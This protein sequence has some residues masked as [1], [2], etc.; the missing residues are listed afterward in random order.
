MPDDTAPEHPGILR[1]DPA[2]AVMQPLELDPAD[3]QSP[4]PVQHYVPFFEDE[5][6]G[7][8]VGI[9]DTTTMQEAFGPYPGDEFITV[10]DGSFA[11]VDAAGDRL[12]EGRAGDSV[13]FRNA[14]P[15]SWK[16][17]GYLRKIYLTLVPPGAETPVL[18]SAQGGVTVLSGKGLAGD[19]SEVTLFS[20][21][22][23]TMTVT[24]RR[25]AEAVQPAMRTVAHELCRILTGGMVL[26]DAAGQAHVLGPGDHVFLPAGLTIGRATRAGTTA[27]HV[28]VTA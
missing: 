23:G 9:W 4:L 1:I 7:L 2:H 20:N 19:G 28:H 21:D 18:A 14:I 22:A 16:Q 10:L 8:A 17:E 27:Y 12:A 11:M 13:T 3:F 25:H 5:R 6:I 26:T 15:T 24:F